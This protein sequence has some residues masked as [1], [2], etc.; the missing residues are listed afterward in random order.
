MS[1]KSNFLILPIRIFI[2]GIYFLYFHVQLH[3]QFTSVANNYND[4]IK[5]SGALISNT[6][7]DNKVGEGDLTN[8]ASHLKIN[9]LNKR[10]NPEYIFGIIPSQSQV[11][12]DYSPLYRNIN[13]SAPEL[14][15]HFLSLVLFRGPPA[16]V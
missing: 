5:V 12:R 7:I 14:S 4:A 1:K 2:I 11:A 8:G 3:L 16:I 15:N 13:T 10:Y 6:N 9:R